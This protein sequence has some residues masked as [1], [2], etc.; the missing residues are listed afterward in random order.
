VKP[1]F[2]GLRKQVM[3]Q[4]SNSTQGVRTRSQSNRTMANSSSSANASV[5]QAAIGFLLNESSS[6]VNYPSMPRL[7]ST[8]NTHFNTWKTKALHYFDQHG[9]R[10]TVRYSC[11]ESL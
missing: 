6:N 3:S 4:V 7:E 11:E 2:P 8:S 1:P 9:L 10:N 5:T